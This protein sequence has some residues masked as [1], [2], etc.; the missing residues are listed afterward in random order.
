MD[1]AIAASAA[2]IV[3]SGGCYVSFAGIFH[4]IYYE[5]S[6]G[7]VHYLNG[8]YNSV[9]NDTD[10]STIPPVGSPPF[11]RQVLVPGYMRA[12]ESAHSKF[13]T[14]GVTFGDLLKPAIDLASTVGF[15][16][17]PLLG[18]NLK[19]HWDVVRILPIFVCEFVLLMDDTV[20]LLITTDVTRVSLRFPE[21]PMAQ[22]CFRRR[23]ESETYS[24]N[25]M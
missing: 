11:G 8:N 7:K 12:I 3:V 6:T 16:W 22:S 19:S 20:E 10:P 9:M 24:N 1:A 5:A 23:C 15:S 2:Q 21:R 4:A 14:A 18:G 13:G 17:T 25:Q